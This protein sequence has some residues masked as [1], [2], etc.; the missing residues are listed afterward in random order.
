VT[1]PDATAPI[2]HRGVPA[3]LAGPMA[4]GARARAQMH[5]QGVP[6]TSAAALRV[7]T[8]RATLIGQ[9]VVARRCDSRRAHVGGYALIAAMSGRAPNR[10]RV[11]IDPQGLQ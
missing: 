1:R 7:V 11:T 5:R 4:I 8:L 3:R 6:C 9:V 2:R 10:R